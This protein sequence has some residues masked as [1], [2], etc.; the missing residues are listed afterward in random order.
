[1]KKLIVIVPA[2]CEE[3][4]IAETITGLRSMADA[5]EALGLETAV[6]VINDGS[7]D[8]TV[9]KAIEAGADR[10]VHHRVN[11]GL[12]AAV[13]TGFHAAWRDGADI[14]VKF[15]ADLQHDPSDIPA[16]VQPIL[17]DEAEIVY[18]NRFE[19]LRYKMPFVRRVGNIAFTKLMRWLTKWPL[20][21]SQ[22][23]VLAVSKDYLRVAYIPGDYNY[24]QQIL[25]DAYHQ[26]MRFAQ[27]PVTFRSRNSGTSFVSLKYPF[28]VLPQIMQVLVGV[29]PL[30]VFGPLSLVFFAGA[31]LTILVNLYLWTLGYNP[32]PVQN[33]N[34]V[35][36]SGLF[37]LQTLF[38]GLLADLIVNQHAGSRRLGG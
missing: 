34:L 20:K 8:D 7:T 3:D 23:G 36:G 35:L 4:T 31:V 33:V 25:L 9:S 12:G 26:G 17:D 1:M 11:Q 19:R 5:L 18:G 29:R 2:F 21:D 27:V 24:T 37:G 6:Y 32:K 10:V 38:F 16:L 15:D 22:P 14:A 28:K 30:R 13:R